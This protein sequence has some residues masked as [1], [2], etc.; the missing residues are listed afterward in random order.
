VPQRQFALTLAQAAD[1]RQN[2]PDRVRRQQYPML[3]GAE[4]LFA[5]PFCDMRPLARAPAFHFVLVQEPQRNRGGNIGCHE[6]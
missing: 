6:L 5:E 3:L 2:A 4:T 1:R